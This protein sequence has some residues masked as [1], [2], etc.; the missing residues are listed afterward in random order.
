MFVSKHT[1]Q[2]FQSR[3]P[4]VCLAEKRTRAKGRQLPSIILVRINSIKPSRVAARGTSPAA[5][6]YPVTRHHTSRKKISAHLGPGPG[7][8]KI[9]PHFLPRSKSQPGFVV[10]R[11]FLCHQA[12][13]TPG[14][15]RVDKLLRLA[16]VCG[17]K[18]V[19]RFSFGSTCCSSRVPV[20]PAPLVLTRSKCQI[21]RNHGRL[22]GRA[23]KVVPAHAFTCSLNG[24]KS[25]SVSSWDPRLEALTRPG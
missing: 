5:A 21:G 19:G 16:F 3:D 7:M 23:C 24:L 17:E 20:R 6:P 9:D 8:V 13:K 12:L 11:A 18:R 4:M 15:Y 22:P 14:I 10:A 2:R 1:V 25:F